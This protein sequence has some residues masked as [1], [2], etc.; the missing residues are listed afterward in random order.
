VRPIH[1]QGIEKILVR[2]T[3]W[4][5][6]AIMSLPALKEVRQRF[7]NA[8]IS[9]LVRPWVRDVYAEVDCIDQILIYEKPGRHETWMGM[10]RLAV[11][12]RAH[13]FDLTILLQNAIEAAMI[14]FWARIPIRIGYARDGRGLL[15]THPIPIDPEVKGVHQAYYYLGILSGAGLMADKLWR[16]PEYKIK[17]MDI[18]VRDAD[19]AA[20][21]KILAAHG[22]GAE[23]RI[24]GINPGAAYGSAKRWLPE[25]FASVADQLAAEFQARIVIFGVAN[26]SQ[27]A[28]EIGA[29]MAA[30][31]VIL[32]GR[33]SLGELMALL[34]ECALFLTN[35]SGPMHLAAALRVPQLAIFGSTSEI[36]TGPLSAD[37]KVIKHPVDCNPCFLRECPIDFRCMKGISVEEVVSAARAKLRQTQAWAKSKA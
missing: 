11:E 10:R 34:R 22:I 15:L 37:A 18:G 3:N 27:I 17:S 30:Q 23:D 13:R 36:A 1:A 35:D 19:V 20:A 28:E 12:L 21:R 24:I 4:V 25:R 26:E 7:S 16:R 9:L 32:A 31:P 14:A 33:T 5:G 29:R 2:G 6:D 8:H